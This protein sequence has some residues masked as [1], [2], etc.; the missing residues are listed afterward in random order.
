MPETTLVLLPAI[1]RDWAEQHHRC[2]SMV[3]ALDMSKRLEGM[4]PFLEAD[5]DQKLGGRGRRISIGRV[6]IKEA[7][8]DCASFFYDYYTLRGPY[9]M[10]T[11][12]QRM[13]QQ[14]YA[15]E[16]QARKQGYD[17]FTL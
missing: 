10:R 6:T 13:Y 15:L 2:A 7:W 4:A 11:R 16:R 9:W 8:L 17:E 14:A 5:A 3:K 1:S 12:K